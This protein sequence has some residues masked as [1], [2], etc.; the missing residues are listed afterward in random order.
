ML[1]ASAVDSAFLSVLFRLLVPCFVFLLVRRPPL[2][3]LFPYTTLFRSLVH[4]A[5]AFGADDYAVA[6]QYGLAF[7]NPVAP[8][9]TFQDT[10]WPE[11]NGRLVT[12]KETN[13][14]ILER[15]KH[16]GRW[17][18]TLP[19]THTYPFCWRCDSALI[20]Y[21]RSSWFVRTT[22]AKARMLEVNAQVAWHPPEVGSGRFGAWLENNVDWALSRDRYWGTPLNV[23]ECDADAEHREVIGSYADLAERWGKRLPKDFDPHK[24]AIDQ[25]TWRCRG[26][27]G[28]MRRVLEVIDA[29]FDS[30]AM[31][32]A[33]WHYPFEHQADFKAH[34]PAD[35]ICE[36]VDQTRGWF[37]SLL[38]IGVTAL[39]ALV[40]KNVIVNELVLDA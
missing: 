38:A 36:G 9:G 17:L 7:V 23:W 1:T 8:D 30:G 34:F 35:F 40:Y 31:P 16:E 22:A 20:Y 6:Q 12:D 37:Y 29:W 10:R 15:L 2:S 26:C 19:Y 28:T 4:M 27:G 21:A 18:E 13:R 32:Y 11:I 3:I 33:Q 5:P 24:P 39:D 14:L 25:Y